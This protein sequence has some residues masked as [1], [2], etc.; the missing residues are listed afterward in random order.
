MNVWIVLS[1]IL[2]PALF[3]LG[4]FYYKDRFQPE[5]LERIGAAY[6]LGMAAAL[7]CL[8]A[9]RVLPLVG[10]PYDPSA[11][12]E[13]DRLGFLVYSLAVTGLVEEI[14]KFMPFVLFVLRFQCFDESTDGILYACFIALGFASVENIRYL[15]HLEG[16]ELLGR[17]FASPLTH[18]IFSSIWGYSIGRAHMSG[19]MRVRA[20]A[21]GLMLAAVSHGLFNFLTASTA[22]RLLSS[23]LILSV[24]IWRIR[25]LE[26]SVQ[27]GEEA[28]ARIR[29]GDS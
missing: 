21:V 28:A 17:A 22:L 18:T 26:R 2:A 4:Y 12:M 5:P 6:L 16:V 10:L 8:A 14:F 11:L 9:L 29:N 19:A 25:L 27:R 24:W 3:W 15:P 20:A 13:G 23:L 7:A 1:G